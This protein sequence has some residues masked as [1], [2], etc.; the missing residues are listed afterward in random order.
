MLSS[1]RSYD[2]GE[3]GEDH[4]S[5]T[6]LGELSILSYHNSRALLFGWCLILTIRPKANWLLSRDEFY[7]TMIDFR[8]FSR[9]SREQLTRKDRDG[10][11]LVNLKHRNCSGSAASLPDPEL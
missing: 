5:D 10:I 11:P 6:Q 2:T 8:F 4:Q 3:E 9:I 1:L 7:R